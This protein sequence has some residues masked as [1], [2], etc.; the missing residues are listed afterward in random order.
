MALM[1]PKKAARQQ[2]LLREG[3]AGGGARAEAVGATA[4]ERGKLARHQLPYEARADATRLPASLTW[5]GTGADSVG[6]KDQATCGSCWCA[7]LPGPASRAGPAPGSA[8]L[9]A[10]PPPGPPP[11]A[12][13]LPQALPTPSRRQR[14]RCAL[15]ASR[16]PPACASTAAAAPAPCRSFAATGAMEGAWWLSTGQAVSLSEQQILDCSWGYRP[17]RPEANLGEGLGWGSRSR[18]RG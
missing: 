13:W 16:A 9:P 4:E 14:Q 12:G 2:R 6:V 8:P 1:L 15:A 11:L 18:S 5:R 10:A 7:C 3:G 17:E